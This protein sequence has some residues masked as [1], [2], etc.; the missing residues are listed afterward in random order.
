MGIAKSAIAIALI[1][2]PRRNR[3]FRRVVFSV[4]ISI[5]LSQRRRG[6]FGCE[7]CDYVGDLCRRERLAG[8][9][10]LPIG[11]ADIGASRDHDRAQVL[12][13]DERQVGSVHDRTGG[14]T[15]A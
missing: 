7:P 15:F 9:V 12:V 11:M 10:V 6:T 13:A 4:S 8:G 2:I 3:K 14:A 1:A 5:A